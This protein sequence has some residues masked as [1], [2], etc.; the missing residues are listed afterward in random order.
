VRGLGAARAGLLTGLA[1]VAAALAG[2][3]LGGPAPAPV[4]W[5]GI[6]VVVAGLVIGLRPDAPTPTH[7]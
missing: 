4:V 7:S 1:P 2:V 3:L 5:A 6:A